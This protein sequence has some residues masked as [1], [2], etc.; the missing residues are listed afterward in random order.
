M[1]ELIL[2]ESVSARNEKLAKLTQDASLDH[3][4]KAKSLVMSVWQGSGIATT[5]QMADYYE[6]SV[7][8]IKT[9]LH[10]NR[11]E[12]ESDGLK[13]LKGKA[14]KDVRFIMNLTSD[15]IPSLTT[16]TPRSALR[17]GMLLRDSEIA[18]QV[19]TLLLDLS[20]LAPSQPALPQTFSEALRLLADQVDANQK[21]IAANQSLEIEVQTLEPKADRYDL[22]LATD[23]WMTGEEICKQL[24]IPKFSN[25]KLYDILRQEKVLFK[26][27]DG[28]N[29]PYAEWVNEG[30]AKL[31]DGQCFDGRMR[32]SPAFSWKGLDRILDLLRKH[33]VIPKDKQY[34]FNFDSDKIVAMKRA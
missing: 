31:R 8:T 32:F 12:L 11:E 19:R 26:R 30:L 15:K 13:V 16:W 9:V 28:T 7:E 34:R 33:Q 29:C 17:L 5:E 10:R 25:R 1:S 27:P 2:L 20:E 23:G 18:K 14:L 4:N 3:L 6:V 22:I 24:A 21:L